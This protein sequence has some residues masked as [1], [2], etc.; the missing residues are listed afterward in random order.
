MRK[1]T[2]FAKE[3]LIKNGYTC[4]LCRGEENYN[5]TLR[6]VKPLIDFLESGR[7][8]CG[9][10][11]ADKTVGAGAAHLYALLGI[12]ELWANVISEEGKRV[13]EKNGITVFYE[14][15]VP[16]II[17]RAGDGVCPIETA[18]RGISDSN[19]AL[20]AIKSALKKLQSRVE[21]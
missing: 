5:S 15:L 7:D 17:N 18:V 19:E 13:L 20:L 16:Y 21:E 3:N 1:E 8:F 12:T 2:L 9:F 6:G 11:A 10:F 14:K 4:V